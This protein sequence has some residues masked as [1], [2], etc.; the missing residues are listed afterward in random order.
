MK[1]AS[2][3][4]CRCPIATPAPKASCPQ[5]IASL[6][7]EN[8]YRRSGIQFLPFNTL[9]QLRALSQQQPALIKRVAHA[10]LIPDYFCFRLTGALNWEYTNAT[11]TQLVNI[12]TDN[13]DDTLLNWAGIP[14]AGSARPP[15]LATLSASGSAA[16][17]AAS[18]WFQ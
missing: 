11:T 13:W 17:A 4:G 16:K 15:T 7:R 8:I 18:R 10:L 12:N 9:Y 3:S 1:T 5:A 14:P 2:A 6:G